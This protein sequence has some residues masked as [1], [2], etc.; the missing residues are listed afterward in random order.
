LV[1][2]VSPRAN[3]VDR[4]PTVSVP[5][6]EPWFDNRDEGVEV[7]CLV[8]DRPRTGELEDEPFAAEYRRFEAADAPCLEVDRVVPGDEVLVVEDVRL[9]G[10]EIESL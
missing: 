5:A 9:T 4:T 8:P 10:V 2:D 1:G 7:A 3:P 6:G